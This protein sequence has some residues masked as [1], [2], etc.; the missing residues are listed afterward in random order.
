MTSGVPQG[1]VLGP[2]CFVVFI[3]DIDE[4]LD[5]VNGFVYKFADNSKYGRVIR[6]EEDQR[7]MQE[8]INQLMYWANAGKWN[9]ILSSVG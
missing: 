4:V 6:S 2:A 7:A 5:L 8:D 3:D 9:L 1:S